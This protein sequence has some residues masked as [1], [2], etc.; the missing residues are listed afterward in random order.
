VLASGSTYKQSLMAR[1]GYPFTI[2]PADIDE[3]PG[4]DEAPRAIAERL[5]LEKARHVALRHP[6]A[7]VLGCDQVIALDGAQLHKP[8]TRERAIEQLLMLQGHTHDLFCAIALVS[9]DGSARAATVHYAMTMRPMTRELIERYV[10]E[11]E[12]LDCAGSYKL[13]QGGVRL[14]SSM[15]GDDYTA[16]V[17]LP[18]TR[19]HALLDEVG[20]TR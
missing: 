1:L 20:F 2:D 3:T 6:D 16:I 8:R 5:A 12:P 7:L 10:H 14:F 15:R 11:D 17:G 9:P 18:L 13:E 4:A 19:V